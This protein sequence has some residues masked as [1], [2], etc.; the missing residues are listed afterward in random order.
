MNATPFAAAVTLLLALGGCAEAP[1]VP[2][3][4]GAAVATADGAA[5][6]LICHMETPTGTNFPRRYCRSAE[7]VAA[8]AEGVAAAERQ[9]TQDGGVAAQ[10]QMKGRGY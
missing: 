5:P 9:V 1:P 2:P 4:T 8:D 6:K 7:A 10:Q 3:T